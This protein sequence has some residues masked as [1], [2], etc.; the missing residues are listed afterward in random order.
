MGIYGALYAAVSG[1]NANSNELSIIS[2][3]I[4]N[5]GTVGYKEGQAAFSTL[6]V[7]SGS[8]SYSPGGVVGLNA[9]QVTT[10]G[11]LTST[12][13]ATDIA[14]SGGGLFV[15]NTE[16]NQSGSVEYTRAG[17]FTANSLGDFVNTAGLYLQ[18]WPLDQNGLLP[19]QPGNLNTTSSANLNSLQT[20]NV[21]SLTGSA[22]P[23]TSVSVGTNLNASQK[24][25]TGAGGDVTMDALD[26]SNFGITASDIIVPTGVDKLTRGDTMT[27]ATTSPTTSSNLSYNYVYGGFS[28]GRSAATGTGGDNA[29]AIKSSP[30][31]TAIHTV[32]GGSANVNITL[33]SSDGLA[34]G[35]VITLTPPGGGPYG[36]G[37]TI[38]DA[39]LTGK[40]VVQSV[41]GNV[42]TVTTNGADTAVGGTAIAVGAAVENDRPYA[43]DILDADNGSQPFLGITG[44][45]GITSAGLTFKITTAA[46]GTVSF[47][48][49][50][51]SP[52]AQLGQFNNMNNLADAINDVAGL[53]ARVVNNQLYVGATDATAA[54]TFSNGGTI[55]SGVNG[56]SV[57]SGIDWVREL[58]LANVSAQANRF[59]S[60]TSLA[61]LVNASTGLTATT[62]NPLQNATTSINAE[63]PQGT[64]TFTDAASGNTGSVLAALG[65]VTS[66]NSG[67]YTP[68][69]TGALGPSYDPTVSS[70]NM[71][72]GAIAPDF[73]SPTTVYDALGTAHNINIGFLK[74]GSN[75]WS[76]EVYAQ[77]ASDV[78]SSLP[79]G[80]ILNGSFTFNGDGTLR[81][82]TTTPA[83]SAGQPVAVNWTNGSAASEMSFDWGT[84]GLPFGTLGAL[85]IGKS[86]GLSQ[87][88]SGFATNFVNHNGAPVGQLTSIS[89]DQTGK[90][91][92]NYNNGQSTA[93]Y[94]IP[95]ADFTAPDNLQAVTGNA[96]V[97]TN[98]SGDVS[99]KETG[100]S[101]VGT[102]SSG[103]LEASNVELASQLTT[104][105]V[106]QRAYQANTEVIK[107]ASTLLDSLNQIIQ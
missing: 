93:L 25:F 24:I 44:T 87:F 62:Q 13:S 76:V 9:P 34:V 26:S 28:I 85:S 15:V 40:F 74:T 22:S 20:V 64:I 52:N 51:S 31:I 63:D 102:I 29:L 27:V 14:I 33:A 105:I 10:Q 78:S 16:A 17:S 71:A 75:T 11:L 70:K 86:D 8:G 92:A 59:S 60:Q 100:Q 61:N 1:L 32:G 90:I 4:A 12:G 67:A 88:D 98:G 73:S 36:T 57:Q 21:Q 18:A 80:Q 46:S 55:G 68:K 95:L 66:L 69:T 50:P 103:T 89:I 84:A 79:N 91:I 81:S 83:A 107:T 2:D 82:V 41:S 30:A 106:A 5:V 7:D 39:E 6:V 96:Y 49:T 94:Q 42:I 35:D 23:T 54:V 99:L 97:Q 45:A 38:T 101:G 58:G 48:Y 43:G 3:N 77:P 47:T 72:S 37:A 56:T 65:L 19:G 53:T 104:M